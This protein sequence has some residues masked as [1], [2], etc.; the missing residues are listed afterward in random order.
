M[1]DLN[2]CGV[3]EC[4]TARSE[5]VFKA[6]VFKF[7]YYGTEQKVYIQWVHIWSLH[8]RESAVQNMSSQYHRIRINRL[9]KM[10]DSVQ[11]NKWLETLQM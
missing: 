6:K 1:M 9:M 11:I 4:G 5:Q 8:L 2:C 3:G 7:Q 10:S